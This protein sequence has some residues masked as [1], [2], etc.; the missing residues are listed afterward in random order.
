MPRRQQN[1]RGGPDLEVDLDSGLVRNL[2]TGAEVT[3]VPLSDVEAE[4][5]KAGGLLAYLKDRA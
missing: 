1:R 3:G 2:D 5:S 4:I